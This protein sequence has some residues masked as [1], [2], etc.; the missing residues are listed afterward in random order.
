MSSLHHALDAIQKVDDDLYAVPFPDGT[1]IVFCLPSYRKALQYYGL[2]SIAGNDGALLSAIYNNIFSH[3]C[4]NKFM[5]ND[6]QTLPAGVPETVSKLVLF[7]SGVGSSTIDYTQSLLD[8]Y[9]QTVNGVIE[10]MKRSICQTFSGYKYHELDNLN[11]QQLISIYVQAEK[12]LKDA[13]IIS[14]EGL[15]I[16]K[17]GDKKEKPFSIEETISKDAK[18]YHRFENTSTGQSLHDD[19][20]YKA[21]LEQEKMRRMRQ[22]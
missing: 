11:Y 13:G 3:V 10:T 17:P 20:R 1:E 19:P 4:Q 9:R 6:S 18:D 22:S 12:V 5:A 14:D 21:R 7:L 2:V 15:I 16:Q 8:S